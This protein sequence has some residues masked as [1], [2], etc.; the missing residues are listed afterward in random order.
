MMVNP[1][2]S[3]TFKGSFRGE[4]HPRIF[5]FLTLQVSFFLK[6][7]NFIAISTI[8][9]PKSKTNLPYPRPPKHQGKKYRPSRWRLKFG[10]H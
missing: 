9:F 7:N 6:I 2:M 1:N 3:S 8:M 10:H 5:I 4:L